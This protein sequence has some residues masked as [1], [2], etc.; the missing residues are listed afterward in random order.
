MKNCLKYANTIFFLKTTIFLKNKIFPS[1]SIIYKNK[2]DCNNR[3]ASATW[4]L[5]SWPING[6]Y[7][8]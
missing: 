8:E 2:N 4:P 7:F 3:L 6:E 5:L 1:I